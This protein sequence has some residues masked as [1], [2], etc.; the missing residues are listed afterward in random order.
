MKTVETKH[1][2]EKGENIV[3]H[4]CDFIK[5]CRDNAA[6][7]S[8]H[9]WY[10]MFANLAVFKGGTELIHAISRPY[11]KY[12]LQNTQK[13][14]N[15]YLESGTRPITC[16]TI[17]EKGFKCPRMAS[18]DCKCKAPAA[19]CYQPMSLDGLRAIIAD[20]HA[21]NAVVD[22]IQT[23]RNFVEEYLYNEDTVTAETI[24]NYEIKGHLDL[25]TLI[26]NR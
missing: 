24:I 17:A 13:K 16:Q 19:I 11:P 18:G 8:E 14:I 21:K 9:D 3:L 15:H 4:E 20:L 6:T 12:D 1:G 2:T 22:D 25:R 5:F 10:A 23:A 26:L 7:L